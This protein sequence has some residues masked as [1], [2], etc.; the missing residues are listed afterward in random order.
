VGDKGHDPND[1]DAFSAELLELSL[2]R[3]ERGYSTS[4]KV[5]ITNRS[6]SQ[7]A[8]MTFRDV[9]GNIVD[10]LRE[11]MTALEGHSLQRF[12]PEEP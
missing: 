4:F 7:S 1:E 2:E 9:P 10:L 5:S 3:T 8:V 11:L 6:N 12:F